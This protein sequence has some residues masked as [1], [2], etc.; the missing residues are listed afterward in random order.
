MKAPLLEWARPL[1]M[2]RQQ[3]ER[4]TGV[5]VWIVMND[6][7]AFNANVLEGDVILKLNDEDVT[8][9]TDFVE[10]CTKFAGQKVVSRIVN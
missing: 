9:A 8:S 7:P 3:L 10:K 6:S 4:N 1:P 5:F 2:I